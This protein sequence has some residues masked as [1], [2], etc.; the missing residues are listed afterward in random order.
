MRAIISVIGKDEIGILAKVSGLCAEKKANIVAVTQSVVEGYFS[1]TMIIQ[2]E[3]MTC[4]IGELQ[5]L[6][7]DRLPETK[8]RVMHEDIFYEMHRI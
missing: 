1:M 2:V 7:D 4:T 6:L 3:D 8:N 5:D